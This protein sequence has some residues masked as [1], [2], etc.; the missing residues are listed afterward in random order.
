MFIWPP[1]S[2]VPLE[3]DPEDM[4]TE[5]IPLPKPVLD[6]YCPKCGTEK[7]WIVIEQRKGAEWLCSKC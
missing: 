2:T 6:K 5:E 1:G 7:K 4:V 3:L